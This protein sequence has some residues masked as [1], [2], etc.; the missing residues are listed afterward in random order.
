MQRLLTKTF[1]CLK[2]CGS[3]HEHVPYGKAEENCGNLLLANWFVFADMDLFDTISFQNRG[4]DVSR[5]MCLCFGIE[6][7]D[8][9]LQ[10]AS[11]RK[12]VSF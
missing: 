9:F 4:S 5:L 8:F 3:I 6:Y 1:L 2:I 10:K 12:P 7:S 11:F